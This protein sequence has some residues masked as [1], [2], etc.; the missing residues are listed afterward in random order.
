MTNEAYL[1]YNAHNM[2]KALKRR[3]GVECRSESPGWCKGVRRQMPNMVLEPEWGKT[4][5]GQPVTAFE[6]ASA[7]NQGGTAMTKPSPLFSQGDGFLSYK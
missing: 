3:V 5:P 6:A 7:A 2:E 1:D 4:L